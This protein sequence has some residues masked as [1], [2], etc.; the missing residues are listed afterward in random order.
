MSVHIEAKPGEIA[1]K[2]L[3]PGDPL[4]AKYIAETF[5]ENPVCYNQVRG[6]LGYTGTY[7]GER[8][9]V[10]GTGMGMPSAMI[11]AHELVNS[12]DVKKLIRVGTCG[13]L[14]KD[15]HVRDLVL[16]QGA[17]TSSSMIENNFNAFHFPP[18]CDFDLLLKAYE[19]AKEKGFTTHVGNVL[20]ED[21]FYKDDL[22]ETFKLAELGVMGVEMEAAALYYLGAKYQVQTLAIMTVSDHLITGEETTASERQTTFND[23]IEVGLETAIQG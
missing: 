20:S 14:S 23:M 4:R 7:K 2:I 16:A 5:L 12:Y 13:A 15:V 9:S 3:L 8:V 18:I 17:A 22:T 21:S 6:M 19:V 1:D 10:Q 11:Y